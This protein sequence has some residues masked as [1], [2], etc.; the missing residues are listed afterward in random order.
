METRSWVQ[1]VVYTALLLVTLEQRAQ[2]EAP[3]FWLRQGTLLPRPPAPMLF[4]GGQ[5]PEADEC[6]DQGSVDR[7]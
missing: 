5:A 2:G 1:P 7:A 4:C 6:L 3:V